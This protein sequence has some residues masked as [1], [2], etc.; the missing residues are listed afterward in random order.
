M[1]WKENLQKLSVVADEHN[2]LITE[3]GAKAIELGEY[4]LSDSYV[5]TKVY[6][7]NLRCQINL[8]NEA[9]V[10]LTVQAALTKEILEEWERDGV[11][12]SP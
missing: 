2:K 6:C 3:S 1:G 12:F 8:L 11:P 4:I 5:P 10:A 9:I 7:D